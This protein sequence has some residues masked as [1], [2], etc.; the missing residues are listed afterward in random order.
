MGILLDLEE[1]IPT[2]K[3]HTYIR[4]IST[5]LDYLCVDTGG[6]EIMVSHIPFGVGTSAKKAFVKS[7]SA[8]Q[9]LGGA[10]SAEG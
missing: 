2:T 3:L 7:A 6:T 5:T 10:D 9:K 4:E 8:E 1:I